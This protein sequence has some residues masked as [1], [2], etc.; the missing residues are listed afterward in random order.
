MIYDFFKQENPEPGN[1][2]CFQEIGIGIRDC[3]R[4]FSCFLCE[5][6]ETLLTSDQTTRSLLLYRRLDSTTPIIA[7]S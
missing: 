7:E 2:F 3:S 1:G 6:S 4:L 5:T